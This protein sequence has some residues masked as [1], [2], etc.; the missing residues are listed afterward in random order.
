MRTFAE[1]LSD[2]RAEGL[3]RSMRVIKGAMGSRVEMDGREMLLLCSN[4][5]LGIAD[6]PALM[7]AARE[8]LALGTSSG[9]SRLVSGTM[10][11]HDEL[12]QRL[13]AFK[14]T[15]RALVFNSGYAAN[16]GIISAL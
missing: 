15:E 10:E 13:A 14:G 2:L 5:Y 6:H 4:N 16:T 11:L 8:A 1:E 12:E 9:A 7:Q 3:Y